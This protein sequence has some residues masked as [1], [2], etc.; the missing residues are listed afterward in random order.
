MKLKKNFNFTLYANYVFFTEINANLILTQFLI[1]F[2]FRTFL[3][4]RPHII[5]IIYKYNSFSILIM[6]FIQL[7]QL[8]RILDNFI[9]YF[10][11]AGSISALDL[12]IFFYILFM[13]FML[14]VSFVIY[15]S[16]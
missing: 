13:L 9:F 11:D 12:L 16:Y 15:Y 6:K 5:I 3:L 1:F 7:V 14:I 8:V 2:E 10:R 4:Q